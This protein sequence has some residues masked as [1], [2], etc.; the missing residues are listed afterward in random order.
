MIS[1][2]ARKLASAGQL[3]IPERIVSATVACSNAGV[4]SLV[5]LAMPRRAGR[6]YSAGGTASTGHGAT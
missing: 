6:R 5:V 1:A 4:I 2:I 3:M